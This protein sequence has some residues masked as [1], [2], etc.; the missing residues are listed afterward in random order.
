MSKRLRL[1]HVHRWRGPVDWYLEAD[2]LLASDQRGFDRHYR[3]FYYEDIRSVTVWPTG[4]MAAHLLLEALATFLATSVAWS[5]HSSRWVELALALGAAA[6]LTEY[7]LG[8][9]TMACIETV[10]STF[11]APLVNRWRGAARVLERIE[12]RLPAEAAGQ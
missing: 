10:H 2:H 12:A 8:Q 9:R 4:A 5:L 1:S 6:M 11:Q 3:R 7:A